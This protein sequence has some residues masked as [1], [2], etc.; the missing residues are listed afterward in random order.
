MLAFDADWQPIKCPEGWMSSDVAYGGIVDLVAVIKENNKPL[1]WAT[2]WTTGG[3]GASIEAKKDQQLRFY[4][5][6]LW[7]LYGI[8]NV[9]ITVDSLRTGARKTI[10]LTERDHQLTQLFAESESRRLIALDP[11]DP[12]HWPATPGANCSICQLDCPWYANE[13]IKLIDKMDAADPE[14]MFQSGLI[15]EKTLGMIKKALKGHAQFHAPIKLNGMV[16][17]IRGTK[18]Y[19]WDY[20]ETRALLTELGYDPDLIGALNVTNLRKHLRNDDHLE[21]VMN[22]AT[23][24]V[25]ERFGFYKQKAGEA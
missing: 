10:D 1:I 21:A 20:N 8:P 25:Q 16:A 5:L 3:L 15:V 23:E 2:D 18:R 17:E 9:R 13:A 19:E 22:L 7:K 4:A 11:D 14:A 12:E 6:L 24:S